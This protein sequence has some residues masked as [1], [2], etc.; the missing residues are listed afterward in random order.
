MVGPTD[1]W[2]VNAS[3]TAPQHDGSVGRVIPLQLG[4]AW[5]Q[6]YPSVIIQVVIPVETRT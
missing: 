2:L 1:T 5:V 3:D 6:I 4:G